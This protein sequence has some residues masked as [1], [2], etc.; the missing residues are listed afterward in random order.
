MVT[1]DI[2]MGVLRNTCAP[3][4]RFM[5]HKVGCSFVICDMESIKP[6]LMF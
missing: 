4:V 5:P 6:S 3:K 1:I 2:G